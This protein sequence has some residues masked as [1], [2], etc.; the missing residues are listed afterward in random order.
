MI[1]VKLEKVIQTLQPLLNQLFQLLLYMVMLVVIVKTILAITSYIISPRRQLI[2]IAPT[3][4]GVRYLTETEAK[5][6][7]LSLK[8]LGRP[9]IVA[10][11]LLRDV[12]LKHN[13]PLSLSDIK[14]ILKAI[15]MYFHDLPME[16][17]PPT[18]M[19]L[20]PPG[21]G[22]SVAV[23][24]VARELAEQL[25]YAFVE[26]TEEEAERILTGEFEKVH[27]KKPFVFVDFRLTEV[28]PADLLG[29]PQV[30]E[31]KEYYVY[32]PPKWALVL[33]KYP[34]V[35]FLDELTN[36]QRPDVLALSYKVTLDRKV[37]FVEFHPKVLI[38]AAG[39][40]PEWSILAR[41]FPFPLTSRMLIFEV[42]LPLEVDKLS[43][44]IDSWK[45]WMNER[46][47]DKWAKEVYTFLKSYPMKF[48][49]FLQ[50]PE[51]VPRATL[52]PYAC[53]REWTMFAL[54]VKP[55]L[56]KLKEIDRKIFEAE[57]KKDVELVKKFE[58]E[59]KKIIETIREIGRASILDVIEL[60][61]AGI[62]YK[63][64]P[65]EEVLKDPKLLLKVDPRALWYE[66]HLLADLCELYYKAGK[67]YEFA[68]K[69]A[70]LID[71]YK[72]RYKEL[73]E[74]V[75][76]GVKISSLKER[77]EQLRE[78][79]ESLKALLEYEPRRKEEILK[80]ISSIQAELE[81]I[82]REYKE[83][84]NEF[85]IAA[86]IQIYDK[87]LTSILPEE[88][89][90]EFMEALKKVRAGIEVLV[91][92]VEDLHATLTSV[93]KDLEELLK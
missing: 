28:E 45:D 64:V 63:M 21:I 38:V 49:P 8:E 68:E 58:E 81:K 35:L 53:P 36:V 15:Y 12:A 89:A 47:D 76:E 39:N 46:Y 40:P 27:G 90:K 50:R 92:R 18:I 9:V 70:K 23:R 88:V 10:L 1:G 24:D 91:S 7:I 52:K 73:Q 26:Y 44:E 48:Y 14:N 79:L 71:Y 84:I 33:Q 54:T 69:Y 43:R 75:I 93:A 87:L 83:V 74:K 13:D 37:G 6:E 19:L 56:D 4:R 78:Q 61:L 22:K 34:G 16:I 32:R 2:T 67:I 41:A 80:Q 30:P 25:G 66:F 57:K 29:I 11:E 82:E 65:P 3:T 72:K 60:F 20:G 59:R 31:G 5:Y 86:S 42:S 85:S 62:S 51:A 55:H 77:Y 17:K